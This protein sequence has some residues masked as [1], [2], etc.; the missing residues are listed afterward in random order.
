MGIQVN[1]HCQAL[2]SLR[3][4]GGH[5]EICKLNQCRDDSPVWEPLAWRIK[6]KFLTIRLCRHLGQCF[7]NCGFGL[8]ASTSS[9]NFWNFKFPN[10]LNQRLW[11]WDPAICYKI[12][13]G[14]SNGGAKLKPC[15]F[16]SLQNLCTC[17]SS[18]LQCPSS[19]PSQLRASLWPHLKHRFLKEAQ[20]LQIRLC[21][22]IIY[23]KRSPYFSFIALTSL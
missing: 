19:L 10:L 2:P 11:G 9:G 17:C 18:C 23:C 7:S 12:I 3:G 21:S 20:T 5:L 1:T 16:L 22:P 6:Y 8:T 15:Y 4:R 14:D 13:S